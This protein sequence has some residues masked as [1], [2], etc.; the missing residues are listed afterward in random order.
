[1]CIG[2]LKVLAQLVGKIYHVCCVHYQYTKASHWNKSY[3]IFLGMEKK[4]EKNSK[5]EICKKCFSSKQSQKQH[6]TLI[7][8]AEDPH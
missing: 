4:V 3:S 8:D 1:M 2:K 7:H 6:I 5:C